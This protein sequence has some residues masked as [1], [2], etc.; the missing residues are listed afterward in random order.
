MC[1]R[2]LCDGNAA[3]LG[4]RHAGAGG[5][6]ERRR[7][8]RRS[9][10]GLPDAAGGA[11]YLDYTDTVFGQ[12]YEGVGVVD[13]IAQTAVDENRSPLRPSPPSTASALRRIRK[14]KRKKAPVAVGA[15]FAAQISPGCSL[16]H[17][18]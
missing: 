13:A 10:G 11:P 12:V 1:Q 5:S 6:D 15:F 3:R 17:A 18:R 16:R 2:L 9:R 8:P 4:L 14:R 7:L